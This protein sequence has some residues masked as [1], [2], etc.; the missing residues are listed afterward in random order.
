MKYQD[1]RGRYVPEIVPDEDLEQ[2]KYHGA[3]MG[4]GNS[5][6]VLFVDITTL[7]RERE[8]PYRGQ[9]GDGVIEANVQLLEAARSAD[10]PLFYTRPMNRADSENFRRFKGHFDRKKDRPK[11]SG[12]ASGEFEIHPAIEPRDQDLVVPKPKP[13]MFYGTPLSSLLREG[14]VDTVIVTGMTTSGCVRATAIDALSR[15]FYTIVPPECCAD[16]ANVSHDLTLFELDMKY[17]D[18]T[19]LETVLDRIEATFVATAD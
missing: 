3:R 8:E 13:S 19:P 15:D 18:V 4:W 16:R 1:D 14:G 7:A 10:L 12:L 2:F 5:P 11:D 6:A 9:T 17:A